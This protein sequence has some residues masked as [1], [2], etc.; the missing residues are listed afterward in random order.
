MR[1]NLFEFATSELSQD[2]VLA[3]LLAWADNQYKSTDLRLHALAQKFM[4]ALLKLHEVNPEALEYSSVNVRRQVF[5]VDIVVEVG[6]GVVI[7]I[8]DKTH[9]ELHSGNEH[10]IEK[11]GS[12]YPGKRV[13]PIFLKTGD[14]AGYDNVSS[15]G[16]KPFL[17]ADL[18]AILRE[19]A[20]LLSENAILSDF[21]AFLEKRESNVNEWQQAPIEV[22]HKKPALWIGFYEKLRQE[23][24]DLNWKYVS[25]AMGG[26]IGAWWHWRDWNG[27]KIYLQINQGPLQFR[28]HGLSKELN[29][30]AFCSDAFVKLQDL[31]SVKNLQLAKSHIHHGSTMAIAQVEMLEWLIPN[32]DGK[33][34]LQCTLHRLEA[35]GEVIESLPN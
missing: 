8:E 26:F 23:F 33:I 32:A 15:K 12:S 3:W 27:V 30:R 19:D 28:I 35:A 24:V 9:T 29:Y 7:A 2:A 11:L 22:W 25:N 14:Q 4:F 1:P 10:G 16:F 17:R 6:N 31:A 21:A 18:L 5:R 20:C 13:L 34:D